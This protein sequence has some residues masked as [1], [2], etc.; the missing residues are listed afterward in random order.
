MCCTKWIIDELNKEL[1]NVK[2]SEMI[3]S[4]HVSYFFYLML[5]IH[6]ELISDMNAFQIVLSCIIL[7]VA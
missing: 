5:L 7:H 6:H 4:V 2:G 3:Q 1:W